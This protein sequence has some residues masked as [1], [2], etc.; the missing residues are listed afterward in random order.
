MQLTNQAQTVVV[1]N[2][3]QILSVIG[4]L[5]LTNMSGG[6]KLVWIMSSIIVM[7]IGALLAVGVINCMVIGEC[8]SF[9]W[10]IVGLF[11]IYF[12]MAM[13]AAIAY[14]MNGFQSWLEPKSLLTDPLGT[15]KTVVVTDPPP[16]ERRRV[17]KYEYDDDDDEDDEHKDRNKWYWDPIKK[18]YYRV[19]YS[20]KYDR[21]YRRYYDVENKRWYKTKYEWKDHDDNDSD[22][23]H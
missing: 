23:E 10:L 17:K 11:I 12:M 15:R 18:K 1:L 14:R 2:I 22:D 5:L 19:F 6:W 21:Y 13:V 9:A 20:D 4:F 3:I 7:S 8:H 16:P